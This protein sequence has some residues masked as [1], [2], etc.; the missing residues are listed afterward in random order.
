MHQR[1]HRSA[2]TKSNFC[3]FVSSCRGCKM[4]TYELPCSSLCSNG[5]YSSSIPLPFSVNIVLFWKIEKNPNFN[6]KNLFFV[7][8]ISFYHGQSI[9]M[10]RKSSPMYLRQYVVLI[11]KCTYDGSMFI[12][13]MSSLDWFI[14]PNDRDNS[15]YI[16]FCCE[17]WKKRKWVASSHCWNSSKSIH[18]SFY[19]CIIECGAFQF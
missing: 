4:E 5:S 11:K 17:S 19:S 13:L 9:Y 18:F 16:S 12:Y 8:K 6:L 15:K 2:K 7:L 10:R 1:T 3:I 14:A